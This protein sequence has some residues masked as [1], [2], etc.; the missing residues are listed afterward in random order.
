MEKSWVKKLKIDLILVVLVFLELLIP[1]ILYFTGT[2]E[3]DIIM[4]IATTF[5]SFFL[6]AAV[7]GIMIWSYRQTTPISVL[8]MPMRI[9]WILFCSV[10]LLNNFKAFNFLG[11]F[12]VGGYHLSVLSFL[13]VF[14]LKYSVRI[15]IDNYYD[16]VQ[17]ILMNIKDNK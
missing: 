15:S 8:K 16:Q 7:I 3:A 12:V 5:L 1:F 10:L 4:I 2:Y 17:S 13:I 11:Y 6:G 14:E 9:H